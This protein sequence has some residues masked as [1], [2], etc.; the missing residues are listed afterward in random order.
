MKNEGLNDIPLPPSARRLWWDYMKPD[1]DGNFG[2]YVWHPIKIGPDPYQLNGL[3]LAIY[4]EDD[5]DHMAFWED[6]YRL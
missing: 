2:S 3:I 6:T 5:P 4:N 1:N